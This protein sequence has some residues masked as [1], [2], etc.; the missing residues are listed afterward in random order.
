MRIKTENLINNCLVV[1]VDDG[2]QHR[3]KLSYVLVLFVM[4]QSL[5]VVHKVNSFS[6]LNERCLFV[7]P[8][9]YKQID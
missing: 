9:I 4:Y 3:Y 8:N 6:E 2:T 7:C 5:F 1:V